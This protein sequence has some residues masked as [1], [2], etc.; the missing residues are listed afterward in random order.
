MAAAATPFNVRV[1][2]KPDASFGQTI[3]E[4]ISWLDQE[5]SQ[6]F[7]VT[8]VATRKNGVGFEVGFNSEAE[9]NS[10]QRRFA[11]DARRLC[12]IAGPR[13]TTLSARLRTMAHELEEQAEE[14]DRVLFTPEAP[15]DPA[16]ELAA[17][18]ELSDGAFAAGNYLA[19]ANRLFGGASEPRQDRVADILEK[20]SG[21]LERV[22][23][24]VHRLRKL[25]KL[26]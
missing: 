5:K 21:Q 7:S 26:G 4:I 2:K 1:E 24:A 12:D 19:A 10:F 16:E 13:Q 15:K 25:L 11:L 18:H 14:L 8:P 17:F 6:P 23:D 9:A 20:A 3:S 22:N